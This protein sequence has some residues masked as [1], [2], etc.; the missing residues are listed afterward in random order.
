MH[1]RATSFPLIWSFAEPH[2][3]GSPHPMTELSPSIP[4]IWPFHSID[5]WYPMHPRLVLTNGKDTIKRV[6]SKIIS[7]FL[8]LRVWV[9]SKHCVKDNHKS[10]TIQIIGHKKR[11]RH[12]PV[13]LPIDAFDAIWMSERQADQ[14]SFSSTA[15]GKVNRPLVRLVN[16]FL[17]VG[18]MV[19]KFRRRIPLTQSGIS[20][21]FAMPAT[22][23]LTN[24]T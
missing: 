12:R 9:S 10:R 21:R 8:L 11:Q 19:V 13:L 4:Y 18:S 15:V 24:L 5:D 16:F 17:A 20:P 1:Y 23:R 14:K 7:I 2:S 22:T 6:K 3:S